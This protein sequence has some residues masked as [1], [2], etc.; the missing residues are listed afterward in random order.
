RFPVHGAHRD[1]HSFPTRRSSDL[2]SNQ[3]GSYT[4]V[5]GNSAGSVTSAVATLTVY[6]PA[7]IAT[8]P[9]SQTVTQGV[10]ATFTVM[11]SGTAPLK[12][13]KSTSLNSMHDATTD[14]V[15]CF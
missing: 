8:Q 11:G 3:A 14:A 6:V 13:R 9:L 15:V 7:G 1:R 12:D 2:Q 4:V 10:N 5:V